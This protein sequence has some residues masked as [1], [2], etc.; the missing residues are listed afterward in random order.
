MFAARTILDS[1]TDLF[2]PPAC[3]VCSRHAARDGLCLRCRICVLSIDIDTPFELQSARA[4]FSYNG[5]VRQ[6]VYGM[7][8]GRQRWRVRAAGRA[9]AALA[10]PSVYCV[11]PVPGSRSGVRQRGYDVAQLM[12]GRVA[13]CNNLRLVGALRRSRCS[14]RQTTRSLEQRAD[15]ESLRASLHVVA[16]L[17]GHVLLVDDVAT[18]GATLAACALAALDAGASRVSALTFARTNR[19]DGGTGGSVP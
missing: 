8:F 2:W 13:R 17:D 12:A 19:F 15:F 18:T 9:M 7:K 5:S 11:V 1:S 14:V 6:A 4:M 16:E 10:P 3:A